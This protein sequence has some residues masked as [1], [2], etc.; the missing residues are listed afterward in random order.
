MIVKNEAHII[1]RCLESVKNIID[2]LVVCDTGS[3]DDTIK[4][5]ADFMEKNKIKG[6]IKKIIFHNFSQARNEALEI[7]KNYSD[8]ILFLDADMVLVNNGF[9]KEDLN[10]DVY[11][12]IQ[13]NKGIQYR[14]IRI[15]KSD[16][17][18]FYQGFTHEVLRCQELLEE[19]LLSTLYIDDV[20]DGGSKENKLSRDIDLLQ[21]DEKNSRTIF[22]L[23]N[24]HF[25]LFQFSQ[26]EK[27]YKLY[28]QMSTWSEELWFSLYRLGIIAS[29]RSN[30]KEIL[31]F[32]NKCD[33][34]NGKRIEH[35]YY[36]YLHYLRKRYFRKAYNILEKILDNLYNNR[37]YFLFIDEKIYN[38]D[39][40][41]EM[42]NLKDYINININHGFSL[43]YK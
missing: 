1:K 20:D 19:E 28:L 9:K 24:T 41:K 42:N 16:K 30:E 40:K 23:A 11:F 32:F 38:L 35:L 5:I 2:F 7:A 27:N 39:W 43:H 25:S 29:I 17:N 8:Y 37:D 15:V 3:S 31:Y 13:K 6:L 33:Q 36:L 21:Q 34:V 26:A 18:W 4:I 12:L 22:Y 14:N 10:K